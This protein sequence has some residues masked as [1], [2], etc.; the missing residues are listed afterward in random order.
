METYVIGSTH[1]QSKQ[2][3]TGKLELT[4]IEQSQLIE[5]QW[6]WQSLL[7][8]LSFICC[9]HCLHGVRWQVRRRGDN[10]K[11][12]FASQQALRPC[13][14]ALSNDYTASDL[15]LDCRSW[16][17]RSQKDWTFCGEMP[18][19]VE[20][21]VWFWWKCPLH[22]KKRCMCMAEWRAQGLTTIEQKGRIAKARNISLEGTPVA[23]SMGNK[24]THVVSHSLFL[25][26]VVSFGWGV[27]V[28]RTIH[29]V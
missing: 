5:F 29:R 18:D 10:S 9:V 11:W 20:C 19:R 28:W 13:K 21:H 23:P 27:N 15:P 24:P 14:T 1:Q 22:L 7:G 17:P 25:C 8:N 16:Q 26:V 3:P 6:R 12:C 2:W 4:E